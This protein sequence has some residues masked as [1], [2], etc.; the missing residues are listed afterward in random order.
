MV[1]GLN[2]F[3]TQI[4]HSYTSG[5]LSENCYNQGPTRSPT[6]P[7]LTT[8]ASGNIE[9]YQEAAPNLC[10]VTPPVIFHQDAPAFSPSV[11]PRGDKWPAL[12]A[13]AD[14][15]H[16]APAL[17]ETA[18]ESA[19]PVAFGSGKINS[20]CARRTNGQTASPS[21]PTDQDSDV[22]S[23]ASIVESDGESDYVESAENSPMSLSNTL[24][25]EVHIVELDEMHEVAEDYLVK[26]SQPMVLFSRIDDSELSEL[27]NAETDPPEN[28][29]DNGATLPVNTHPSPPH[30][31]LEDA[32]VA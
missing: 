12:P 8:N 28:H 23:V 19:A 18:S 24:D 10:Q 31:S 27:N 20:N 4:N 29:Q 3:L 11:L 30:S 14:T 22:T 13:R 7:R 15:A 17:T 9:E 26:L 16:A 1:A 6:A 32:L 21:P 5:C 2:W 25:L